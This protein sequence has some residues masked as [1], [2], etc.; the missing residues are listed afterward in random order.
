ML[1]C[2]QVV[3][4][5]FCVCARA[6]RRLKAA[7]QQLL[8]KDSCALDVAGAVQLLLQVHVAVSKHF[9]TAALNL[10][11]SATDPAS[12][13]S[14][15]QGSLV[16]P[17]QQAQSPGQDSHRQSHQALSAHSSSINH[18]APQP[19]QPAAPAATGP[20]AG[21]IGRTSKR[22]KRRATRLRKARLAAAWQELGR[23]SFTLAALSASGL[24]AEFL[25]PLPHDLDAAAARASL[26]KQLQAAHTTTA[27]ASAGSPDRKGGDSAGSSSRSS[28]AD[29]SD[30]CPVAPSMDT[31]AL[32][33]LE[34]L[35]TAA[36]A[37]TAQAQ[38]ALAD[39]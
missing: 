21:S 24:I 12:A 19:A 6:L 16:K 7:E 11:A 5:L 32:Q 18:A 2:A 13:S 29:R 4:C 14:R 28:S 22:Q 33:E 35:V 31:K 1:R 8:G 34:W 25:P 26:C 15:Q 17:S 20:K 39:R 3:C 37:G 38:M 30:S 36:A 23:A 10:T 9:G 27:A